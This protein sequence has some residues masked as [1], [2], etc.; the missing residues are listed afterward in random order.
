MTQK[1][2]KHGPPKLEEL[3]LQNFCSL[4]EREKKKYKT[5]NDDL[6]IKAKMKT[7]R[8]GTDQ[9]LLNFFPN[10]YCNYSQLLH[11]VLLI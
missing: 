4:K 2:Q 6:I 3:T 10:Q 1:T 9:E 5:S 8:I 11:S 7:Q